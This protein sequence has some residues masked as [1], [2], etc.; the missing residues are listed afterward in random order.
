MEEFA[1]KAI[2]CDPKHLNWNFWFADFYSET[3]TQTQPN[4]QHALLSF[5]AN[6]KIYFK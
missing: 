6:L 4:A 3:V 5:S 1:N 2:I